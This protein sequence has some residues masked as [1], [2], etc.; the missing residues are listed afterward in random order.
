MSEINRRVLVGIIVISLLLGLGRWLWFS[1]VAGAID[2]HVHVRAA[3]SFY[4]GLAD[5]MNYP[6]WD[7]TAYNGRGTPMPRFLGPLPL[8]IAAFFQLM[9][10]EAV[11]AV[12]I[13]LTLFALF[14][15][16]G[17]YRWIAYIGLARTFPWVALFFMVNP[18]VSFHLGV[19]FLFQNLCAY[20]LSPWL[21]YAASMVWRKER[22]AV[23]CGALVLGN[24]ALSHLY[25]ALMVG[26]A[27]LF[28][29]LISWLTVRNRLFCIAAF[30]VPV[31]A[32]CFAAPYLL[33]AMLTTGDVY[34]EEL[35]RN[36][37][38]GRAV[39]GCEFIDDAVLNENGQAL[40]WWQSLPALTKAPSE[41]LPPDQ[42]DTGEVTSLLQVI[43]AEKQ[44]I[45]LR[46]WLLLALALCFILA[47]SGLLRRDVVH[48][49]SHA[50]LWLWLLVGSC[51]AL[52][53]LRFSHN[54]YAVL[55]GAMAVQFPFR[56]LLP[57]F[58]FWLPLVA[59]ASAQVAFVNAA[60][61]RFKL[62]A[63]LLKTLLATILLL[64]LLLQGLFWGLPADSLKSAF[65]APGLLEP[66]QPRVVPNPRA[67]PVAAGVAHRIQ[68]ASGS[69]N[70]SD[71]QAGVAWFKAQ[72]DAHTP[73]EL[74]INTHYDP[75]WRFTMSQT[76]PV[77]PDIDAKDGTMLIKIPTG[78]W[79]LTMNRK[80]PAGRYAGWLLMLISLVII[81]LS[82]R[83]KPFLSLRAQRSDLN[84]IASGLRPSQ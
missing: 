28:F 64:G 38:P 47:C 1:P 17:V 75:G 60:S 48:D 62:L 42:K 39:L 50:P 46:P 9:G 11:I 31:L 27:W 61:F 25:F 40:S 55:P 6:D 54:I 79:S 57:A 2:V 3:W 56:W 12:K 71:Y 63:W 8:V 5:G 21:C 74:R 58:V 18:L 51:C 10:F 7:A 33:P 37:R 67:V 69:G 77:N 52:M 76:G 32:V 24:I 26:Y 66:F 35:T 41:E 80:S 29:M 81:A 45:I 16:Y 22:F 30:A 43:S 78:A 13:V 84:D 49:K 23:A 82:A 20:F 53:T 68:I 83:Q 15:L 70:I 19:A 4:L 73:I 65:A 34:Y 36:L 44:L 59:A 14:G 72:G